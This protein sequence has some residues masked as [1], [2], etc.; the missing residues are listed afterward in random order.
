MSGLFYI[1]P[2]L[3]ALLASYPALNVELRAS[4]RHVDLIEENI[5]VAIRH[6]ELQDSELTQRK[7]ADSPLITVASTDYLAKY[8]VPTSPADVSEHQCISFNAGRG[9]H[10]WRFVDEHGKAIMLMPQGR[11]QSNDGEQLRWRGWALRS[12]RLGWRVRI[13]LRGHWCRC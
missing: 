11:F 4:E 6:G 2:R 9:M 7:L 12:F 8:G 13:W 5:N 3:L 1:L 10:P